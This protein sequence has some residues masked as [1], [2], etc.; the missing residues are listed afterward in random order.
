MTSKVS[1]EDKVKVALEYVALF[2]GLD[3]ELYYFY[4]SV[5]QKARFWYYSPENGLK[6]SGMKR[7]HKM[8]DFY[9]RGCY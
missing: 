5:V 3:I 2:K 1:F 4:Y 8:L 7:A 6:R 9:F